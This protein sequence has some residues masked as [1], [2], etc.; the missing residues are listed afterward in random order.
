MNLGS[1]R[2]FLSGGRLLTLLAVLAVVALVT[3]RLAAGFYIDVLWFDSVERASDARQNVEAWGTGS[4]GLGQYSPVAS[5]DGVTVTATGETRTTNVEAVV[6]PNV[7][8]VA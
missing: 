7:G 4:R 6:E 3:T 5:V 2:R 8:I 1:M